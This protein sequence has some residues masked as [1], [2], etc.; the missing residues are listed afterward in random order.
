MDKAKSEDFLK[1]N[2][3]FAGGIAYQHNPMQLAIEQVAL[4]DFY[5]RIIIY[6]RGG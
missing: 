6:P 4:S 1:W 5:S 3:L 2:T